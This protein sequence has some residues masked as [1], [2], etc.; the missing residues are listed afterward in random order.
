MTKVRINGHTS[1]IR[2]DSGAKSNV[3]YDGAAQK[4]SEENISKWPGDDSWD[5]LAQNVA[6]FRPC[7]RNLPEAKLKSFGLMHW[8]RRFQGSLVLTTL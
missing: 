6:A 3:V 5:I 7:P 2:K 1:R 4:V 8:Q